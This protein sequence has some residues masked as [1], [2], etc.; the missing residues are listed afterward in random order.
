MVADEDAIVVIR[1]GQPPV[2]D[3]AGVACHA[4]EATR[5]AALRICRQVVIHPGQRSPT[6]V[7]DYAGHERHGK[8]Y[9]NKGNNAPEN[10]TG[11]H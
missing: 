9:C 7:L 4:L 10:C 6:K 8:S 1:A 3:A 2:L 5:S 11:G